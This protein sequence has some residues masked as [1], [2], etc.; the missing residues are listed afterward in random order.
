MI[1]IEEALGKLEL[2]ILELEE[3]YIDSHQDPLENPD[4]YKF[5]IRSYCLLAHAA[6]E[7]FVENIC[8]YI[9]DEIE[10]KFTNSDRISYSTLCLVH[11][12]GSPKSIDNDKWGNNDRIY[13]Y[14]L[15]QLKEIKT[16][17]SQYIMEHNHGVGL[18]YLKK[19]LIPLGID[20]PAEINSQN[21]LELLVKFRGSYAHSSHR[22]IKT[23]SPDDAKTC[24]HDV[25]E[26]MRALADKARKI[27]Y[28]SIH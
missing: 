10:D 14:F 4:D 27:S 3:K 25:Y 26:M 20:L 7:E 2:Y 22:N 6:F 17:F 21:A 1:N 16:N 15:G 8:L 12:K 24:V 9:L 11:F 23:V 19:L 5:D 18:K 28:Y 13:S